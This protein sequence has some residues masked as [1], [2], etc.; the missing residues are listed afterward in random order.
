MKVTQIFKSARDE[1]II[2]EIEIGDGGGLNPIPI[3]GD[4]VRW[5]YKDITYTGRVKSR[6]ISYSAPDRIGLDRSDEVDVIAAL[7]VELAES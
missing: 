1:Q 4:N 6:L 7:S 3:A 5:I 2:G